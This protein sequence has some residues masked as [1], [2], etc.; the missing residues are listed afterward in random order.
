MSGVDL[1]IYTSKFMIPS[2]FSILFRAFGLGYKNRRRLIIGLV[3]F[4]L[5]LTIVPSLLITLMG[6]GAYTHIVSLVMTISGMLVLIFS[7]PPGKNDFAAFDCCSDEHGGFGSAKY[8]TSHF[9]I[10]LSDAG[11]PAAGCVFHYLPDCSAILGRTS[12]L[13]CRQSGWKAGCAD[14]HSDCYHSVNLCNS[15]LSG[16]K[17]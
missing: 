9:S 6:G 2:V 12:A 4:A 14:V 11:R 15:C 1:A 10:I 7:S 3:V 5:Y 8:D 13:C 16:A 17:F